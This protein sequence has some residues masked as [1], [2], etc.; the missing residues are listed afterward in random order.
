MKK[1]CPLKPRKALIHLVI[2]KFKLLYVRKEHRD[3]PKLGKIFII[4]LIV[5]IYS[6]I[7]FIVSLKN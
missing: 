4:F 6:R 1:I 5:M 3:K 2:L 7:H